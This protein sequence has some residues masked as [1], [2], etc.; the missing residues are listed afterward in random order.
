MNACPTCRRPLADSRTLP[1]YGQWEYVLDG[2]GRV[3]LPRPVRDWLGE[4][5]F[6]A[7][8]GRGLALLP[9]EMLPLLRLF[10]RAGL[11]LD[12]GQAVLV[13]R[14][15]ERR[16]LVPLDLRHRV[17]LAP[18]AHVVLR[19]VDGMVVLMTREEAIR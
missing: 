1:A 14:G 2:K 4:Q 13:N 6:F 16:V 17:G 11:A 12:E 9:V 18:G 19:I 10:P 7:P 5:V 8:R 3:V 15:R